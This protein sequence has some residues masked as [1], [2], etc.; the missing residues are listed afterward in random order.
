MSFLSPPAGTDISGE[1]SMARRRRKQSRRSEEFVSRRPMT[2]LEQVQLLI[3]ALGRVLVDLNKIAGAAVDYV[4]DTGILRQPENEP[5]ANIH[6]SQGL[7]NTPRSIQ[8]I[9]FIPE[10]D[11]GSPLVN[12]DLLD[13][14]NDERT[15]GVLSR[16]R[17]RLDS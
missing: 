1:M 3:D 8:S 6:V 12:T 15:I 14:G 16:L 4:N 10:E 13:R 17:D 5:I 7:A 2:D 9:L 11:D